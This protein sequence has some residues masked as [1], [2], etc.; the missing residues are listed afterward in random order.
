MA[1]MIDVV[2]LLLIFF[3]CT[4]SFKLLESQLPSQLP[5][6]GT[7]E[8]A[9]HDDFD[10]IRIRLS[11]SPT[12]VLVECDGQPCATFAGLTDTLRARSRIADLPVLI[13]GEPFVPFGHMVAALDA[14]HRA[15]LRTVAFSAKGVLR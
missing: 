12:G 10:P 14:C 2:F 5:Q 13:E 8:K 4:A 3:M 15:D 1:S 11:R 9:E 6:A 7:G